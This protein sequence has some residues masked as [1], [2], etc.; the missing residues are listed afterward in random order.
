MRYVLLKGSELRYFLS[1]RVTHCP[2]RGTV[3]V[4]SA[5]LE[6]E[7]RRRG[8]YWVF[9]LRDKSGVSLMRLSTEVHMDF[10]SW[11]HALL[12]AGAQL[13]PGSELDEE[14]DS[15]DERVDS[16]PPSAPAKRA[17]WGLRPSA[18]VHHGRR[19]SLLSGDRVEVS[20]QNGL[21]MLMFLILVTSNARLVLENVIK[22]GFRFN[23]LRLASRILAPSADNLPL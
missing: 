13:A 15:D 3:S 10:L 12:R 5:V 22:Y 14:S 2:P 4:R 18:P 9:H 6:V 20:N 7:G 19:S 16:S 23:P 1:E 17:H 11:C 8:K 21:V